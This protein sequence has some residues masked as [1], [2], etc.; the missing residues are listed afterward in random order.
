MLNGENEKD[1]TIRIQNIILSKCQKD[2]G[3]PVKFGKPREA[4]YNF[5]VVNLSEIHLGM[6][7]RN[8]CILA[9]YGDSSVP[10]HCRRGVFGMWQS[11]SN[12]ATAREKEIYEKLNHFRETINAVIFVRYVKD[13][14][15]L[16]GLF[17]DREL[18]YFMIPGRLISEDDANSITRRLSSFLRAWND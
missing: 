5:I 9:I 17:I 1:D 12:V 10:L 7:D 8:D 18:E 15:F 4:I 16:D 11:L 2:D 6:V 14:G 3:S 13:S